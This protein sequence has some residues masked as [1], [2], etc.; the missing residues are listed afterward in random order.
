MIQYVLIIN[1]SLHSSY[2]KFTQTSINSFK[3]SWIILEVFVIE[4]TA[5]LLRY[6]PFTPLKSSSAFFVTYSDTKLAVVQLLWHPNFSKSTRPCHAHLLFYYFFSFSSLFCRDRTVNTSLHNQFRFYHNFQSTW[7]SKLDMKS[8]IEE[9]DTEVYC[10][11]QV[12][13]ICNKQ[14]F[15][16]LQLNRK[17][18]CLPNKYS[19]RRHGWFLSSA[20]TLNKY[21]MFPSMNVWIDVGKLKR[22][23]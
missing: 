19:C 18:I 11:S 8:L 3:K 12:V 22:Q 16:S 14:I 13:S 5:P 4:S 17:S 2:L 23:I 6:I 15:F 1:Q 20:T 21:H 7:W 9:V 10:C